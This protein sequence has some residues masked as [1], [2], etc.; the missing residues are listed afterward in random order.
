MDSTPCGKSKIIPSVCKCSKSIGRTS[1]G[2]EMCETSPQ[3]PLTIGS[4]TSLPEGS[5][6]K[7]SAPATIGQKGSMASGPDCGL[8]LSESFAHFDLDS[9]SL[10]TSQRSLFG[11]LIEFSAILPRAG[12]MRNGILY[13]LD[14]LAGHTNEID[15]SLWA[16]P[17]ASDAKRMVFSIE[18]HKKQQQRNKR[19]GF[20]IGPAGLNLVAHCQ[21]EFGGCPT[22]AF[23]EWL[24]NFP[25]RWTATD[26]SE[27]P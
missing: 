26:A 21:I 5:P 4:V 3:S 2:G 9:S 14:N 17:Q 27:T 1:G 12:M 24:M 20:G 11:G 6:A 22:A 18:A 13:R 19:L 23:V 7:T 15:F 10:K 16:T 8:N 25:I